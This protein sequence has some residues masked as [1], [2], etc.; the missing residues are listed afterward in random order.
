MVFGCQHKVISWMLMC[1]AGSPHPTHKH[2]N[3]N[4]TLTP[5][6]STYGLPILCLS[7]VKSGPPNTHRLS[8][9]L[10]VL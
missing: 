3:T 7:A 4:T 1:Q 2:T 8:V 5:S 6:L 9:M 10:S